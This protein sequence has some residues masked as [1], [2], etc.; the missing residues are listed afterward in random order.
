MMPTHRIVFLIDVDDTLLANDRI[1][2]DIQ[3]HL[4]AVI[5]LGAAVR[6]S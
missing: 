5:D 2:D 6:A 3:R 1:Q 4:E